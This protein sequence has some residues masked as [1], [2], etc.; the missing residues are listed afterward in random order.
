MPDTSPILALPFL[1]PSQ[2]QKHVTHNEALRRLDIV[3]QL[4]VAAFD[5]TTPPADP[6]DGD[7]HALGAVPVAAWAGHAGDLAAWL[8]GTWHFVTPHEGWRAW[9][10]AEQQMRVWT[11]TAWVLPEATLPPLTELGLGTAADATNR[12]A[13]ASDATLLTHEGAGH[14]LKINKAA[15]GDTASLLYQSNWTGHAE[16]GLAGDTEFSIKVSIDGAAWVEAL[17]FDPASGLASGAAVQSGPADARSGALMTVGAF[18]LGA[19]GDAPLLGDLDATDSAAGAYRYDTNTA[20]T[21]PATVPGSAE[22]SLTLVR[23]TATR[24]AQ[25]MQDDDATAPGLY[26]RA[27]RGG[28]WTDW[29][30]IHTGGSL[31]GPVS[32]TGGLPTGAVIEQGSNAIGHY[33]K[34]AD[35][36]MMTWQATDL[37]SGIAA[38]NGTWSSPYSTD[39][40]GLSFPAT[41]VAPPVPSVTFGNGAG[42]NATTRMVVA[43]FADVQNDGLTGFRARRIGNDASDV[44]VIAYVTAIGRWF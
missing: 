8:D 16:M 3:V 13:V 38:G 29:A 26:H 31:L 37:G 15:D 36:T 35:G 34:L 33:Q 44:T 24:C 7:V 9:G 19:T 32:E 10:K 11:G 27:Y 42:S 2:A 28:A 1:L 30:R 23:E 5:A 14:Q 43:S 21:R 25:Y 40:Q 39:V 4:S 12:L 20:G 22:G 18:G 6:V 17:R 41:F